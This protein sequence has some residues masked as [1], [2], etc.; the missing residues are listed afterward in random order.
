MQLSPQERLIIELLCSISSKTTSEYDTSFI[1]RMLASR[2]EWAIP[3]Q[4]Q[5]LEDDTSKPLYVSEVLAILATYRWISDTINKTGLSEDAIRN[6]FADPGRVPIVFDGFDG[7]NESEHLSA[8]RV[9]INELGRFQEQKD[10]ANNTHGPRRD[11]YIRVA[12]EYIQAAT[13][14]GHQLEQ[15]Q[16][17]LVR[18]LSGG[19]HR[20]FGKV[21]LSPLWS[22]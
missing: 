3:F 15:T 22:K 8:A 7:N 2:Q 5:N 21:E 13:E 9:L 4:Y 10:R 12:N 16:E 14:N 19:A 1:A 20:M 18:V 17:A 11:A 6:M